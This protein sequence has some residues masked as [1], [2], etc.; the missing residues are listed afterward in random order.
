MP[1]PAERRP[2]PSY[3]C[4]E[5]AT[6]SPISPN[7][8]RARPFTGSSRAASRRSPGRWSRRREAGRCIRPII[9]PSARRST[10]CGP[11][12]PRRRRAGVRLRR[13]SRHAARRRHPVGGRDD[14]AVAE[15]ARWLHERDILQL[16]FAGDVPVPALQRAARAAGGG[17]RASS[18][19][20]GGPGEGLGRRGRRRHRDRADRLQP[21]CSR[22]ATSA[23]RSRRKDDLWR[24]IVRGVLDR[25]KP[26]D[27]AVAAAAARDLRRR[28]RDRRAGAATSSRRTTR[29]TARR[30]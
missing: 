24:S 19:R 23:T 17:H 2:T 14:G 9:R 3:R 4:H 13:D 29:W 28:R 16:T 10:A 12:W 15:A 26:L 20:R 27:E 25:R 22:I 5:V 21:A 11:R 7:G 30:C 18:A 1:A 6:I 8:R